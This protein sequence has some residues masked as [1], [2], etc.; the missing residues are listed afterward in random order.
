[1]LQDIQT[2]IVELRKMQQ[3]QVKTGDEI[4]GSDS[5]NTTIVPNDKQN[6][7]EKATEKLE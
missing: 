3:S 2:Q 4:D 1:M 7:L 5:L 6:H